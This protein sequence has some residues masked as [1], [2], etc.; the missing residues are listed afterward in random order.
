MAGPWL[1][2]I[3]A[4]AGRKFDLGDGK[5]VIDATV[6]S[7]RAL[8]NDGRIVDDPYW[9]ISQNWKNI[10]ERDELF[11]YSGDKNLGIIGYARIKGS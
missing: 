7:Y 8:V 10:E 5:P 2:V 9:Y 3:A 1:Y 4:A 11:I 6:D